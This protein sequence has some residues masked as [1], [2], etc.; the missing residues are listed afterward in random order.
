MQAREHLVEV[1]AQLLQ[2][3]G[4]AAV[5]TRGVAQA[6]GVQ[7]PAIY[8]HFADKDG[9]LDAVAEHVFATYVAEKAR[10]ADQGDPLDDLRQGW[11]THLGFG[12]ANPA[13]FRLFANPGPAA[14]AGMQVLRSRVRRVAEI[15]RLRV[16]EERAVQIIQA[17]GSGAVLTLLSLPVGQRD[18]GLTDD[19]FEA[20][21]RVILTD[22]PALETDGPVAA[23]IAFR[24]VVPELPGLTGPERTLLTEWLDRATREPA[25]QRPPDGVLAT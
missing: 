8:R 3:Q 24:T 11:E 18:L 4:P 13:I 5:T 6:A 12:L 1:A 9:L 23:A 7:P 20:V 21:L 16:P 15:G 14:A 10:V 25:A 19:M 17:A 22:A 2:E